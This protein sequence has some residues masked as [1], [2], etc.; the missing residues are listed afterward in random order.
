MLHLAVTKY[1]YDKLRKIRSTREMTLILANLQASLQQTQNS[2]EGTT[3]ETSRLDLPDSSANCWHCIK[4]PQCH[5][6]DHYQGNG[7]HSSHHC[8]E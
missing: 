3:M 6:V 5:H 2:K 1:Q 7:N 4:E 8:H